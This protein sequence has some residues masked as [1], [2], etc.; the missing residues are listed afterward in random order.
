MNREDN[1][2]VNWLNILFV[3][4]PRY[5]FLVWFLI[6][7]GSNEVLKLGRSNKGYKKLKKS[8]PIWQKLLKWNYIRLSK[9]AIGYQ[10]FFVIMTYLGYLCLLILLI[11]WLISMHT[12]NFNKLFEPYLYIKCY[13]IELPALVFTSFNMVRPYDKVG[14]VWRFTRNYSNHKN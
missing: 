8:M 5:T 6:W 14:I 12:A 7:N 1:Q 4:L 2:L 9:L 10:W 3:T 11:I 13:A